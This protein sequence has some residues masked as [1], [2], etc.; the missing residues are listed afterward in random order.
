MVDTTDTDRAGTAQRVLVVDDEADLRSLATRRLRRA[1]YD[2]SEAGDGEAGWDAVLEF[3]PHALVL[4]VRMPRLD[5]IGLT[6]R[7][8]GDERTQDVGIVLLTASVEEHQQA[9]G[10][11]AGA[12]LY[13]RK[14][15]T[16]QQLLDAVASVI[17]TA[18]R[19]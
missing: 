9:A 3:H 5:G 16:T 10:T 15:C 1:G 13:L 12:D 18:G 11:E 17:G 19:A 2:V 6:R 4:D 8:R 14:P 7:L